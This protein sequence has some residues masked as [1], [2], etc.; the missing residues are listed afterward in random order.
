MQ[1]AWL[2]CYFKESQRGCAQ[3][4]EAPSYSRF[5]LSRGVRSCDVGYTAYPRQARKKVDA[6]AGRLYYGE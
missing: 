4:P 1:T 3:M 5:V 2:L 6:A